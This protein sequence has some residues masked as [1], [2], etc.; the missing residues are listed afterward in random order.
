MQ[1]LN[2]GNPWIVSAAQARRHI[3]AVPALLIAC[4]LFA[5]TLRSAPLLYT[6]ASGLTAAHL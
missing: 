1:A 3:P 2:E 5:L 4:G 6:F